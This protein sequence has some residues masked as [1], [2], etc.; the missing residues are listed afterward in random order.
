MTA[1]NSGRAPSWTL[2]AWIA[3]TL[4]TLYALIA[5]F[6][7]AFESDLGWSEWPRGQYVVTGVE[8]LG[9]FIAPV[10]LVLGWLFP[11]HSW[12]W[13]LWLTWPQIALGL[14][15]HRGCPIAP[16]CTSADVEPALMPVPLVALICIAAWLAVKARRYLSGGL[17][18]R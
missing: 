5:A 15:L 14:S 13:G 10:A 17:P 12:R 18:H 6:V 8:V 1:R 2:G 9:V 3:A 11:F 7:W 16:P 4:A